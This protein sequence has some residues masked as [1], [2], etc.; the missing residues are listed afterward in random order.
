MTT[1]APELRRLVDRLMNGEAFSRTEMA[2]L[3]ELLEA[4]D[5]LAYYLSVTSQEGLM[6]EAIAAAEPPVSTRKSFPA[7][8][9]RILF[10][11]AA[12]GAILATG[13]QIGAR[14]AV[15]KPAAAAEVS[16]ARITG[17]MGVD[18]KEGHEPDLLADGSSA[19]RLTFQSGLV[20]VTYASG[21]RVTLEGPADFTV[22]DAASGRLDAGKLVASVPK[23]AE[24][25]RVDYA[26][27]NVVDLGTE[28]VMD[29]RKDGSLELG[30]LD[31]K[32]DLNLP[33]ENPRRL[34]VNQAVLHG[35][36]PG[37]QV[38]AI[39]LNRSKFVRRL[40]ARDFRWNLASLSPKTVEFDV[41]HL[42][43]K[44]SNYR[45][46]FK[47]INGK[48]GMTIRD[49]ALYRDGERVA[50]DDH[51]GKT[52]TL[53]NVSEN[54]YQ[55]DLGRDDYRRGRWKIRATLEPLARTPN[56]VGPVQSEGILQFEEGLASHAGPEDFIGRW[57][58][59]HLGNRYVREFHPDGTMTF[60]INGA[61]VT[62]NFAGSRWRV[63]N[64]V[65]I[66]T[67]PETSPKNL[68]ER[69][70][71]RDARTLIFV[72]QPYDNAVKLDDEAAGK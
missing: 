21:V 71:L 49:V 40:P 41:T 70:V 10:Q 17:L 32:V 26:K 62:R 5:A 20:E 60:E 24:G 67:L 63:E 35:N 30:V 52:G 8:P 58:Y 3:E 53:N 42:I 55:L 68:D 27:G 50:S 7:I 9:A 61:R 2:R 51:S 6:P 47:W 18:W 65:L 39:P 15:P 66:S 25:F 34:L 22:K 59:Y 36:D 44:A 64:G 57:C 14:R 23:G 46:I 31:G 48:D 1:P 45:A 29:A 38:R 12:A 56:L 13:W 33:G 19:G 54:I 43:W 37:E 28:F 4:P 16:A 69:H 72:S 11:A